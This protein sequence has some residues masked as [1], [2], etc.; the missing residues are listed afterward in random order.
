MNSLEK[1]EVIDIAEY[2]KAGKEVPADCAYRIQIDKATFTVEQPCLTGR[3]LLELAGKVPVPK[4]QLNMKLRSGEVRKVSHDE[5][6]CFPK[7]ELERFMTIP[8]DTTEG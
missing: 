1:N 6:I 3:E 7:C 4:Y 8:L 5:R 2:A